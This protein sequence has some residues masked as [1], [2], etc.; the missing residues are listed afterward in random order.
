MPIEYMILKDWPAP[1]S[2]CPNCL[3]KPFVPFLRGQVQ[4]R[5]RRLFHKP[6]C[7]VICSYCKNIVGHEFTKK[8]M[9]EYDY[10]A[11]KEGKVKESN[12]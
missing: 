7:A 10:V 9:E 5:W 3:A 6:Y 11:T 4:S 1:V 2:R 8:D 12:L